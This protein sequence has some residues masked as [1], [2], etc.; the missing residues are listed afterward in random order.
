MF[1]FSNYPLLFLHGSLQNLG[2]EL[3]SVSR[4]G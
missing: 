4:K 2:L 1:F 3:G